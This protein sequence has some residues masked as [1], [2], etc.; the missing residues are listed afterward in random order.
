MDDLPRVR[1]L[2][3]EIRKQGFPAAEKTYRIVLHW[4]AKHN[5][6]T[7]QVNRWMRQLKVR[8]LNG[9]EKE[10]DEFLE[11]KGFDMLSLQLA[12]YPAALRQSTSKTSPLDSLSRNPRPAQTQTQTQTDTKSNDTNTKSNIDNT[13]PTRTTSS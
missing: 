10:I 8:P 13:N 5:L 12:A 7:Q 6:F 9:W 2:W 4:L 1:Q 3:K 11:N